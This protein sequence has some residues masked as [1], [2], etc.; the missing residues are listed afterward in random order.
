LSGK[1]VGLLH[2]TG[3]S[4]ARRVQTDERSVRGQFVLTSG[5][6][7]PERAE[8]T[9]P[10]HVTITS[11]SGGT[12]RRDPIDSSS[13]RITDLT[14]PN[15]IAT[16]LI[17]SEPSGCE[18]T[19]F[20]VAATNQNT[21]CRAAHVKADS[22]YSDGRCYRSPSNKFV[23]IGCSHGE[24]GSALDLFFLSFYAILYCI[25]SWSC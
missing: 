9:C 17:S 1:K 24:L 15:R 13:V 18:A 3:P 21:V 25:I 8:V 19:Q 2:V 11:P 20:A 12:F 16:D 4:W 22:E 5:R 14:S 10:C 7:E 6:F 23:L